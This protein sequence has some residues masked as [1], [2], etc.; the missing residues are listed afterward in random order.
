MGLQWLTGFARRYA[1]NTGAID[2]YTSAN[3]LAKFVNS[4]NSLSS[5]KGIRLTKMLLNMVLIQ[6]ML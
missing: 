4:G 2:A 5:A 6:Q 1:Y 3:K